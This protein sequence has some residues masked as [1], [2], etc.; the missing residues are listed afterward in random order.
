MEKMRK[1]LLSKKKYLS[2]IYTPPNPLRNCIFEQ[3]AHNIGL[4][5]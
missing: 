5:I 2:L 1:K 3:I 4:L